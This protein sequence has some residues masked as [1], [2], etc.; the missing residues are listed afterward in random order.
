MKKLITGYL[1]LFCLLHFKGN[2]QPPSGIQ[3]QSLNGTWAFKTDPNGVGEKQSWF[4]ETVNTSGWDNMPVPGNWDLRNEYAHY[5]GKAW[6]RTTFYTPSTW[7]KQWVRLLFEAVY[8]DSKVWLNGHLLGSNNSGFL[9]FEFE[10]NKW[11]HYDN[12]ESYKK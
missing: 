8:H 4:G 3:Q 9:P 2:A 10:V 11:L 7:Q 6:Y 5:V 1:V 12:M